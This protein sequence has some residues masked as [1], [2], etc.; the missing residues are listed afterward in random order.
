MS[1]YCVSVSIYFKCDSLWLKHSVN[2]LLPASGWQLV[3][4]FSCPRFN[5]KIQTSRGQLVSFRN[6]RKRF[7]RVFHELHFQ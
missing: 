6:V 7:L 1:Y 3:R 2:M 5:G 4:P